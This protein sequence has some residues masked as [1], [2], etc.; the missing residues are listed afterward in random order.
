MLSKTIIEKNIENPISGICGNI[1]LIEAAIAPRSALIFIMFPAIRRVTIKKA[2]F[3]EY[4]LDITVVNPLP[5]IIPILAQ[6][7]TITVIKGYRNND[8]HK[9]PNPN[10][11]PAWE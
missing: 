7:P 2:I 1:S 11:A 4:F 10:F 5:V 3:F 9:R 6:I 8:N